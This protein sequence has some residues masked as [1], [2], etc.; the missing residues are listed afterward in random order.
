MPEPVGPQTATISPGSNVEVDA[1]QDLVLGAVAEADGLE[2]DRQRAVRRGSAARRHGQRLDRVQ[3]G[4]APPGGRN[5]PL[6]EVDDP[7]E[8]L[9]R[10]DE[11]EHQRQEKR[12]ARRS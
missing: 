6:G 5:R 8:R 7:A 4:E 11:L 2:V 9:E 12:L 3:P 10:P 1:A